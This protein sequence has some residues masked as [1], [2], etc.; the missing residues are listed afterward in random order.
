MSGS[1]VGKPM[2]RPAE[3]EGADAGAEDAGEEAWGA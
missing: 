1:Q 3:A 2:E